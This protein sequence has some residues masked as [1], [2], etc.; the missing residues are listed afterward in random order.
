V[1]A[2]VDQTT[3]LS[4][5]HQRELMRVV[6]STRRACAVVANDN[7]CAFNSFVLRDD[8]NPEQP[9]VNAPMHEQWHQ[10]LSALPR[11]CL[12]AHAEAG[13]TV[14][15]SVGRVLWELGRDPNLRIVIVSETDEKAEEIVSAI[16]RYIDESTELK[17]VFPKLRPAK[18]KRGARAG[19]EEK[20]TDHR[21]T[22]E[23]T[24]FARD[25]SIRACGVF[26][27]IQGARADLVIVD[28]VCTYR[29]ARTKGQRKKLSAWFKQTIASRLTRRARIVFLN[30][31]YHPDDLVHEYAKR[32]GWIARRFPM[33]D[34]I[35][36]KPTWPGRYDL[37]TIAQ[38][39]DILGGEGAPETYRQ[40]DCRA[41]REGSVHFKEDWV[42]RALELGDGLGLIQSLA[43][44]DIPAGAFTVTG[45]D[46]GV[47]K[48]EGSGRSCIF[49]LLVY[50]RG[51]RF[52]DEGGNEVVYPPGSRQVLSVESGHWDGPEIV[53]RARRA[54]ERFGS[55]VFVETNATQ[56][57]L[58][59]FM[60]QQA[61]DETGH[62]V[63]PFPVL[64]FQ[65]GVNKW[66]PALGVTAIGIEM[67]QGRW[68]IPNDNG[69]CA[70]EI[71]EWLGEIYAF[72]PD[73]HTGDRLMACWIGSH[74]AR[75]Y[76]FVAGGNV[77]V[78]AA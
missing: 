62:E 53:K 58:M 40:I 14:A 56:M 19:R 46:I 41:V 72:S 65:T 36:G 28:D 33:R 52:T 39:V 38:K 1:Q 9:F 74:G 12:W 71:A 7:P 5:A 48:H 44:Q 13:K 15:I 63:R 16:R 20:W 29:T 61:Y 31:A 49:T 27:S 35:T 37:A 66:H 51:A 50:P 69:V 3:H 47:G 75:D 6:E 54:H 78:R 11:L 73:T 43:P 57:L 10:M 2:A 70:P 67:S 42:E 59:H 34:P 17:L 24:S 4:I 21:I 30:T 77:D 26:G 76:E 64:A 18:A 25:P 23:R 8:E 22:V 45:V 68:I 60:Q 32:P 55:V